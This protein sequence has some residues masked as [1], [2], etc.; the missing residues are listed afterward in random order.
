MSNRWFSAK[1]LIAGMIFSLAGSHFSLAGSLSLG[2]PDIDQVLRNQTGIHADG[3]EYVSQVANRIEKYKKLGD[4]LFELFYESSGNPNRAG[5]IRTTVRD[6]SPNGTPGSHQARL[7]IFWRPSTD[8]FSWNLYRMVADYFFPTHVKGEE[9]TTWGTLVFQFPDADGLNLIS[10]PSLRRVL[11]ATHQPLSVFS[12]SIFPVREE[13]DP[14]LYQGMMFFFG[15]GAK[16]TEPMY[17]IYFKTGLDPEAKKKGYFL[18]MN[19]E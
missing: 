1:L 19:G 4:C 6:L 14:G 2:L 5:F 13:S 11:G 10:Q 9:D 15:P 18:E 3:C 8:S 17:Q 16:V 7:N 12:I